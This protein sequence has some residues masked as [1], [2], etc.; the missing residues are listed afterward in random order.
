MAR[1]LTRREAIQM[2]ARRK[3]FR[4][5]RPLQPRSCP[6]CG[7]PCASATQAA[8][9]CVGR[10]A[11]AAARPATAPPQSPPWADPQRECPRW[12]YHSTKP[13]VIVKDAQAEAALDDGWGDMPMNAG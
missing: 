1:K 13:P 11:E 7:T 6:R 8:A 12:K 10:N 9:H 5:G 2:A 4:G 3:R